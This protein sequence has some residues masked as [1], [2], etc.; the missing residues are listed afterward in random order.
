MNIKAILNSKEFQAI[1]HAVKVGAYV[2][3]TG[4]VTAIL[5]DLQHNGTL[6]SLI[7]KNPVDAFAFM[8]VDMVLAGFVKYLNLHKQS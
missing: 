8:L 4:F 2:A 3:V 1:E 6:I 5:T 7:A